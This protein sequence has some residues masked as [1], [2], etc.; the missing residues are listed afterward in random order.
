MQ[1]DCIAAL[2]ATDR[3][4]VTGGTELIASTAAPPP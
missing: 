2:T 1:G 4:I 3:D